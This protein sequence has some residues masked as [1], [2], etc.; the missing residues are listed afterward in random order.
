MIFE[1]KDCKMLSFNNMKQCYIYFL[2]YENEVV[3]VGQTRIGIYRPL[4][5]KDKL[6][7]TVALLE[8]A[9]EELDVLEDK[10]IMKYEPIYNR[11][12]N[13]KVRY[14]LNRVK[15][16]IKKIFPQFNMWELK[17]MLP[18]LK[19]DT[20]IDPYTGQPTMSHSDFWKVKEYIKEK[21]KN[22]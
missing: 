10:F 7:D 8:C 17:K 16:Y 14:S 22:G 5:H 3:Y 2:I 6:F 21:N 12:S 13:Y 18:I 11:Q 1:E 15:T 20:I 4:A 9:E 19:I